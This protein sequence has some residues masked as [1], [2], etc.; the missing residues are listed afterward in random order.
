MYKPNE[1]GLPSNQDEADARESC[2]LVSR[3]SAKPVKDV[4]DEDFL[5]FLAHEL[6]EFINTHNDD[7]Y[8]PDL[9]N[10]I[11]IARD[12]YEENK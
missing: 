11:S 10:R 8:V 5:I 12:Y 9:I 7:I 3:P 6:A 1:G 4:I 2:L